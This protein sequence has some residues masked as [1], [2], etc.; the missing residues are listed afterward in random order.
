[1]PCFRPLRAYRSGAGRVEFGKGAVSTSDQPLFIPCGQC[2]GCRA[3]QAQQWAL[4]CVHE[5]QMHEAN[6]F[7]TLTFDNEHLPRDGG[8][9]VRHWQL[10]AKRLRKRVGPFRFF[11]CGEYGEQNL[12]PHY[13]ACLFGVDFL[14]DRLVLRDSGSGGRLWTS[15]VLNATWGQGFCSLGA[16]TYESA[17]YVARY[18][19]KKV[20]GPSMPSYAR[21]DATT[22][23]Y[24]EVKREF[25]TMSRRPGVGA[26][27]FDKYMSD[28]FPSD[29]V[30]H[31]GRR[32]RPPRFYDGRLDSVFLEGVKLKRL[33][34]AVEESRERLAVR[35]EVA[36]RRLTHYRRD[37]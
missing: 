2:V 14:S 11:Q 35:E 26:T 36:E 32:F 20:A 30:V 22:G 25:V 29:E 13:H 23:E 12:R 9:D 31:N 16:L 27:W 28:V 4:R 7:I 17:A 1:M 3:I 15:D 33:E 18:V 5:S 34:K 6:C 10:F 19:M 8:L 37:L 24:F 21:V